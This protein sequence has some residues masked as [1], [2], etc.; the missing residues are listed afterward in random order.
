MKK[1][2]VTKKILISGGGTG[3]HI[4]PAIAIANEIKKRDENNDI[5]FV[6]AK[7]RME[8]EKVPDAGYKIVAL[9]ICGLQRRFIIKNFVVLFKLLI[10]LVKARKII[11]EYNP[12]LVV[13]VGGY[14]SGPVLR[15]ASGM[16]IPTLIQEQNSYA[17]IT[18]RIL[19]RKANTICVAYEG[20]DKYFPKERIVLTG[21]PVREEVH[22]IK[23]KTSEAL[24][25]FNIDGNKKVMLIM[26]G[27]LG[28]RT[29]NES[30]LTNLNLIRESDID[31]IWQTG[32]LYFDAVQKN[33][34]DSKIT[35]IKI[36][37]FIT[38]MDY[39]YSVADVI[40]SRA[41]ASTISELCLVGK[42]MILVPSPNVAEDHQ[43]KNAMALVRH[44][45]ALMIRDSDA[46][47]TLIPE[48]LQLIN[49]SKLIRTLSINSKKLGITNAA[50]R[51]VNE[52]YKLLN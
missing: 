20:M 11:R 51:I 30:V 2:K 24:K 16:G 43:T 8:V 13:G 38:R 19:G 42:P 36:V 44:N 1:Q 22:G 10:S 25:Y 7:G 45:A 12:D 23:T 48:A 27:S 46:K 31:I 21:N 33:L 26:G 35:G 14:A 9:P 49:N 18:N 39:A 32:R 52:I 34:A 15:V 28:A 5:L 41:G 6:G 37:E 4:F 17:G 47:K 29:I 3:G 50:E 40:I